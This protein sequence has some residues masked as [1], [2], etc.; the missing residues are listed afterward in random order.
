GCVDGWCAL[1]ER[2][3][4]LPM[5][6]VLEPAH[7]YAAGGFLASPTLA[8]AA[9]SVATRAGADAFASA[10][11]AGAIVRRPGVGR[12][13]S[14]IA[15]GGRDA[16]YRGEFGAG[17]LALGDG[18]YADDDLAHVNADWV[19][20]LSVDAWERRLWTIPPNSQGYLTLASSWIAAGLPLPDDPDSELWAHLTVE[21]ARAAAYDRDDV[22]HEGADGSAL[23]D[24][25]RL[26][27]RR[28]GIRTETA[29]VYDAESYAGGGTIYLCAVDADRMGVSLIQ[30]NAAGF[31]SLLAERSTGIFLQNRGIGF[32]VDPDHPAAYGPRRR[33]P[34]TLSPALVTTTD[35]ALELVIGTMGGDAQPQVVLQLLT[36][37]L[38]ARKTVGDAIAAPRWV[39]SGQPPFG[40]GFDTWQQRGRVQV[41][42]E[43]DAP[44]QWEIGLR[45]RGHDVVRHPPLGYNVG[46]A[47]AIGVRGHALEAASDPRS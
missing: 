21:A 6:D 10:T 33:P 40:N 47:H 26:A 19:Q 34:H 46:H 24:P 3:G 1:H 11:H 9:P 36:R 35:G 32:S 31:G 2:F 38:H 27:P 45:A 12:T 22:L 42:L 37:L 15:G 17:L 18:E 14:A 43:D 4:R 20:P 8:R 23:L 28:D 39:L 7:A 41:H 44:P 13:L 5:R 16:F 25:S 29:A 30:S